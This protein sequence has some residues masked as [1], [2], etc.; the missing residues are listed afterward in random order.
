MTGLAAISAGSIGGEMGRTV[1]IICSDEPRNGKTLLARLITDCLSLAGPEGFRVFDTD[2]PHGG[3]AGY[4]PGNS[5]IVDFT[6]TQGQ[7][8]VF[9]TIIGEPDHDYVIDLQAS[10]LDRFFAIFEDIGFDT[11]A[12]EAGITVAVYFLID[13]SLTSVAAAARLSG[14]LRHSS[15]IPVRNEALG[16]ILT[17]PEAARIFHEMKKT[18][19][20]VMPRL[21]IPALNRIDEPDFTFAGF[22]ERNGDGETLEMRV[23][24]WNFLESVY[25]QRETAEKGGPVLF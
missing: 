14:M 20:L 4:F 19:D 17:L 5:R 1:S 10:L 9:D 23:E 11:A 22:I 15:F 16:N 13:R 3:L 12:H 8:T 18:R 25:N 2:H 21:S 7:V 24:L 6:R